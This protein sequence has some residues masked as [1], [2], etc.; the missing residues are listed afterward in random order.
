MP[1]VSVAW[2]E[3]DLELEASAQRPRGSLASGRF[4]AY[5]KSDTVED[6]GPASVEADE[7]IAWGRANASVVVVR[8]C[9]D[10]GGAAHFSA[11]AE[12]PKDWQV[13]TLMPCRAKGWTTHAAWRTAG[14][15]LRHRRRQVLITF[16]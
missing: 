16:S 1:V 5:L 9:D 7:A 6:A 13:G 10:F 15:S 14:P 8:V 4:T 2:I 11:G 3:E 12:A